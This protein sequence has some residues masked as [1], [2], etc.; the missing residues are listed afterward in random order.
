MNRGFDVWLGNFRGNKYS[1]SHVNKNI[2]DKEFFDFSWQEM[3]ECDLPAIYGYVLGE[4]RA[5]RLV[6]AG[7]SQGTT[8]M[9]ASMSDVATSRFIQDRTVKM[10]MFAPVVFLTNVGSE[11][12][13]F[14]ARFKSLVGVAAA[15]VG[16]YEI[17]PSDCS[18]SDIWKKL[19]EAVCDLDPTI[20]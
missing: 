3:G 1:H 10:F 13:A 11:L 6:Y 5:E 2:S 17:T 7:Y 18:E 16:L 4:T 19:M 8:A 20:C 9:F 12:L 14:A 15:G